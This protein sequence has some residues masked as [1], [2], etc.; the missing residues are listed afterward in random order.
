MIS[1]E[2]SCSSEFIKLVEKGDKMRG[3]TS[4][5]SLFRN[6]LILEQEC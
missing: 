3:L 4:I 6:E 5:S 2:C 1:D